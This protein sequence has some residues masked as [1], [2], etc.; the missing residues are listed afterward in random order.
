[1][2]ATITMLMAAERIDTLR[3][4]A[5]RER[6]VRAAAPS[7][8]RPERRVPWPG[9]RSFKINGSSRVAPATATTPCPCP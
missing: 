2:H 9:R 1:M 7:P 8:G 4:E 5:D 3:G 6:L